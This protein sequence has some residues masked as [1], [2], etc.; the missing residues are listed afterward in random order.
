[1]SELESKPPLLWLPNPCFTQFL[2]LWFQSSWFLAL[3]LL[4]RPFFASAVFAGQSAQ[5]AFIMSPDCDRDIRGTDVT[6]CFPEPS[7]WICLS[8]PVPWAPCKWIMP[9]KLLQEETK[10]WNPCLVCLSFLG[11]SLSP[12]L[13]WLCRLVSF[14]PHPSQPLTDSTAFWFSMGAARA[15][16]GENKDLEKAQE[17]ES[18]VGDSAAWE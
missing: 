18:P 5:P 13:S 9:M 12:W 15:R 6:C 2:Y 4:P 11:L 8:P 16:S 10:E 7:K 3:N 17:L 1:M 14:E